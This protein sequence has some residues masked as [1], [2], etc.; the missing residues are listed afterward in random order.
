MSWDQITSD[1]IKLRCD[2]M[3]LN[4]RNETKRDENEI[5]RNEIKWNGKKII[6]RNDMKC[7][8]WEINEMRCDEIKR[9]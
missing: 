2:E 8:Y 9:N 1:K 7:M 6:Y 3:E 5:K 4:K